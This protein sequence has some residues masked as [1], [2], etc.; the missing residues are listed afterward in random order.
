[1]NVLYD[2]PN[3]PTF[4]KSRLTKF[5]Y[6]TKGQYEHYQISG[7]N[8]EFVT[9]IQYGIIYQID[10]LYIDRDTKFLYNKLK[11]YDKIANG[12]E[13]K[14]VGYYDGVKVIFFD[15]EEQDVIINGLRTKFGNI[16]KIPNRP[17]PTLP[18]PPEIE[19]TSAEEAQYNSKKPFYILRVIEYQMDFGSHRG[20]IFHKDTAREKEL[21]NKLIKQ[22]DWDWGYRPTLKTREDEIDYKL[23]VLHREM[24][25]TIE[26]DVKHLMKKA[27]KA[28]TKKYPEA[29]R[30]DELDAE[31]GREQVEL[32]GMAEAERETKTTNRKQKE[33][34][35]RAEAK[36]LKD[37]EDR[38]NQLTPEEVKL[39]LSLPVERRKSNIGKDINPQ[40]IGVMNEWVDTKTPNTR[41][42]VKY[43][44]DDRDF[45][46]IKDFKYFKG[47]VYKAWSDSTLYDPD[48]LEPI[49]KISQGAFSDGLKLTPLGQQRL[50]EYKILDAPLEEAERAKKAEADAERKRIKE[51]ED[52]VRRERLAESEAKDKEKNRIKAE[53]AKKIRDERKAKI[54]EVE[55]VSNP[56]TVMERAKAIYGDDV[57][58][59]FSS[60]PTKKYSVYDENGGKI[61]HFGDIQYEDYTKHLDPLRRDNYLA[62]SANIKGDWKDNPFSA[63]NLARRLLWGLD[64]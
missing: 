29:M 12:G 38:A 31:R 37:I 64:E 28:M 32:T 61:V 14:L 44:E 41:K 8:K 6:P 63:N 33:A 16:D 42:W 45:K 59:N 51:E 22:L 46:S 4:D 53:K 9:D 10:N 56:I 55:K 20:Y 13:Y 30:L 3:N 5:T 25:A 50:A 11:S 36:R 43:Y 57:I 62:R 48:T 40:Y 7:K 58:I 34:F 39:E 54:A 1:M 35:D 2:S 52:K 18:Y 60:E 21:I 19:L 24:M 27:M 49:G 17:I 23:S 47:R 26:P 15:R